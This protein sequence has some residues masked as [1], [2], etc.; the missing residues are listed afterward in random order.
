MLNE[1]RPLPRGFAR[2]DQEDIELIQ[3]HMAGLSDHPGYLGLTSKGVILIH[4][5]WP[6]YPLEHGWE[7]ALMSFGN[8]QGSQNEDKVFVQNSYQKT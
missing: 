2:K 8:F 7:N 5:D 3:T 6:I 4:Y 1:L